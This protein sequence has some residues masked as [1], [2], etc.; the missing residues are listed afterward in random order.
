MVDLREGNNRLPLPIPAR[1]IIAVD[2]GVLNA[3]GEFSSPTL[4]ASRSGRAARA[5]DR[6]ECSDTSGSRRLR[7]TV[8]PAV[9]DNQRLS[10]PCLGSM[11][12]RVRR[13]TSIFGLL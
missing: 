10:V 6:E 7:A 9:S 3:N 1:E 11:K 8:D 12:R 5:K 4:A 2:Q 13:L